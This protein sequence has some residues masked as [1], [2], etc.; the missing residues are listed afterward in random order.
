M[1]DLQQAMHKEDVICDQGE[2]KKTSYLS[3]C[4]ITFTATITCEQVS[5]VRAA[6]VRRQERST[7]KVNSSK[8][9]TLETGMSSRSSPHGARSL[10]INRPWRTVHLC[11]TNLPSRSSPV[12]KASGRRGCPP[13]YTAHPPRPPVPPRSPPVEAYRAQHNDDS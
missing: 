5:H 11:P 13:A 6:S 7:A 2:T 10:A 9:A 8:T 12:V 1:N 4:C 3:P